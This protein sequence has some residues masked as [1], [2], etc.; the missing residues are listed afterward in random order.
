[1][2]DIESADLPHPPAHDAAV[3]AMTAHAQGRSRRARKAIESA[4]AQLERSG[5]AIN[6]NAV[7]HAAKVSRSTIYN[8]P[9]LQRRI[10]A[11][12]CPATRPVPDAPA[13]TSTDSSIIA[14]LRAQIHTRDRKITELNSTIRELREALAALYGEIDRL[15]SR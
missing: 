8:H 1:M 10:E 4:L 6:I 14:A 3:A 12:T 15:T 13:P 2:T 5:R 7:A 11:K 9:D